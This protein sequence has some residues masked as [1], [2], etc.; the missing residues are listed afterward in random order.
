MRTVRPRVTPQML[1]GIGLVAALLVIRAVTD[2]GHPRSAMSDLI[3]F[4]PLAA[5]A[6]A[7][8]AV[9]VRNSRLIIDHDTV[10]HVSFFGRAR[11]WP[12]SEVS[13]IDRFSTGYR[14][15]VRYV[16]FVAA[17]GRALFTLTSAIW[18]V[19]AVVDACRHA[20]IHL[21]GKFTD[22]EGTFSLNRRIPGVMTWRSWLVLA[23]VV[24]AIVVLVTIATVLYGPS[25]GG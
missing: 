2:L 22:I 25:S 17:D 19:D 9:A 7:V 23:L 8:L 14:N 18:D 1:G 15:T 3:M 4:G 24:V 6:L 16:V 13:R 20:R 10:T 21:T 11:T 5:A 12:R